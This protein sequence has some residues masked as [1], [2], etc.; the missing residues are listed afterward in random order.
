MNQPAKRPDMR[1]TMPE[2]AK[3]VEEQRR[4][5]GADYVNTCIR[6]AM[7]GEPGWF[8]A[9][10]RGHVLGVPFPPTHNVQQYQDFAVLHGC[11]FAGFIRL[12]KEAPADGAH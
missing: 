7:K 1:A 5:H 8:Y 4:L 3:W 12:P 2:T 11:P 10:E 6:N 9:I